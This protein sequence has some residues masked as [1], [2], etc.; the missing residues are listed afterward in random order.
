MRYRRGRRVRQLALV[1]VAAPAA[2]W[3]LEQAARRAQER[4]K[5]APTSRR[6]RQ[7]ADLVQRFGRGPLANRLG[8]RPATVISTEEPPPPPGSEHGG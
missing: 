3:A 1:L 4:D 5:T 7:G 6:L 2:A 8:R